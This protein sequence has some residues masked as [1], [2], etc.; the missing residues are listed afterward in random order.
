MFRFLIGVAVGVM[1]AKPIASVTSDHL[2]PS[3]RKKFAKVVNEVADRLNE[4]LEES[5]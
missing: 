3:L 1:I 5:P 2:T 4:K